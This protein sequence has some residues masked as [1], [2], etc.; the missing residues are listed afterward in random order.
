MAARRVAVGLYDFPGEGEGQLP[1][2]KN[3][4]LAITGRVSADWLSA[5]RL[6]GSAS[7]IVPNTY[8]KKISAPK[9]QVRALYDF[10]AGAEGQLPFH[11]G[12][13]LTVYTEETGPWL[14]AS[15]GGR[16]GIVPANYMESAAA[17][18]IAPQ[19]GQQQIT[20]DEDLARTMQRQELLAEG[21][22]VGTSNLSSHISEEDKEWLAASKV[23]KTGIDFS[24]MEIKATE[25]PTQ[26]TAR[27]EKGTPGMAGTDFL[28]GKIEAPVF[29]QTMDAFLTKTNI[30]EEPGLFDEVIAV[31]TLPSK[32][33]VADDVQEAGVTHVIYSKQRLS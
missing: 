11:K 30:S 28:T 17:P 13:V 21:A 9:R 2:R 1:F 18:V 31:S 15:L 3:D 22:N 19:H 26:S 33:D 29:A 10:P 8:V 12:D 14:K 16:K 5:E 20:S 6:D 4:K 23:T 27:H 25:Q 7:G 24:R 32:E